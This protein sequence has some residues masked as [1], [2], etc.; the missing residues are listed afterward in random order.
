MKKPVSRLAVIAGIEAVAAVALFVGAYKI[1]S[2]RFSPEKAAMDY[3]ETK[4]DREWSQAYDFCDFPNSDLLTKKMFVEANANNTEPL[5]YKSVNITDVKQ[6]TGDAV[7]K[8]GDLASIFGAESDDYDD[9]MEDLEDELEDQD[10]KV[11]CVVYRKRRRQQISRIHN[12]DKNRKEK[13][14]FLGR[15]EGCRYRKL[16]QRCYIYNTGKCRIT[17]EW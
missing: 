7:S 9:Y 11:Y 14:S 10:L 12:D 13:I 2:N 8:L 4:A 3:W 15:M 17:V 16:G 6:L 1:M 5:E